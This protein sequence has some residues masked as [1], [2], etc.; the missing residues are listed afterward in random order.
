MRLP[1]PAEFWLNTVDL[2]FSLAFRTGCS[3]SVVM[4]TYIADLQKMAVAEWL[5]SFNS[6]RGPMES[7][8]II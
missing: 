4:H 2:S 7:L 5:Q 1:A 6:V 3:Q 8:G